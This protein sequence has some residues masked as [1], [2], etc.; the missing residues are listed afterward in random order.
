MLA[1]PAADHTVATLVDTGGNEEGKTLSRETVFAV[2]SR[3]AA[4]FDA[5]HHN[6]ALKPAKTV[7]AV[8][9]V[10]TMAISDANK[11]VMLE[12]D[13][14]VELL[15]KGLLVGSPRR[16]EQGGDAMQE[17]VAGLVLS[18]SLFEPWAEA[19]SYTHL[20]LPTSG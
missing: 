9:R 6:S 16:G 20:T 11:R 7:P 17:A 14:V 13:G 4:W 18:L 5:S 8:A 12:F 10:A 3:V 15:C 1:L 19:V 2:L